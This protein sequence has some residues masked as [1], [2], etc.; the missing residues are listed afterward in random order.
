MAQADQRGWGQG[1]PGPS[2]VCFLCSRQTFATPKTCLTGLEHTKVSVTLNLKTKSC[3]ARKRKGRK[4]CQ[5]TSVD[6]HGLKNSWPRSWNHLL[7]TVNKQKVCY[8]LLLVSSEPQI[9][10]SF[11]MTPALGPGNQMYNMVSGLKLLRSWLGRQMHRQIIVKK[12]ASDEIHV[13]KVAMETEPKGTL[14]CGRRR[15]PRAG[16]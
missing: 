3:G 15:D 6:P 4:G 13:C 12:S 2:P 14:P 5:S 16:I 8:F 11:M 9:N 1:H 10:D 7:E